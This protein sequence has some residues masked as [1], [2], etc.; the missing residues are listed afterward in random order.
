MALGVVL[1]V[2]LSF[3]SSARSDVPKVANKQNLAKKALSIA[4]CLAQV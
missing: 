2:I 1:V 3:V 4:P